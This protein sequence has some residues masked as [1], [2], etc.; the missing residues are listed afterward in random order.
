MHSLHQVSNFLVGAAVIHVA[1]LM[2]VFL[3]VKRD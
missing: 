1:D 3:K 2:F